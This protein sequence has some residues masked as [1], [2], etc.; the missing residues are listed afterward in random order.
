LRSAP[1][2]G[3][4]RRGAGSPIN[5]RAIGEVPFFWFNEQRDATVRHPSGLL[6]SGYEKLRKPRHENIAGSFPHT[7]SE[8]NDHQAAG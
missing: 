5:G 6:V 1:P 7:I 3:V 4:A 8:M 2:G